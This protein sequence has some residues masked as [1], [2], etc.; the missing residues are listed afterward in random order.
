MLGVLSDIKNVVKKTLSGTDSKE[1]AQGFT[2]ENDVRC[3]PDVENQ[4]R[5]ANKPETPYQVDPESGKPILE[6]NVLGWISQT[7]DDT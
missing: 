4:L 2:T 6:Q 5:F 3:T 7:I 1:Y